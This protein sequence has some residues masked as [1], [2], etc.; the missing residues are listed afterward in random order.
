M[1]WIYLVIVKA[2]I[3]N[4]RRYDRKLLFT[5]TCNQDPS[6]WNGLRGMDRNWSLR[7][8]YIRYDDFP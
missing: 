8:C 2:V 7:D 6:D 1:A 4:N 5:G 3:G